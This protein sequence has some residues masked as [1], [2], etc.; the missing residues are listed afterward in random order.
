LSGTSNS[1]S[2]DALGTSTSGYGTL[3]SACWGS[4]MTANSGS[5]GNF[6]IVRLTG[7]VIPVEL[8]SFTASIIDNNVT[9]NWSTASETNNNG[10]EIERNSGN[11]FITIGFVQGYG[12]TTEVQNYTFADNGL[13]PGTYSYRLKQIDFDGT[14][15]Y[16]DAI[17][18]DVLAPTEFSLEQNYPNPFNPETVIKYTVAKE[19]FVN[20]SVYDVLGQK[21]AELVNET[22]K[23]GRHEVNFDASHLSSGVYFYKLST[24][25]FDKAAEFTR[26]K[27]MILTK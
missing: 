12:T 21:V 20:L 26:I 15:E 22:T 4:G 6:T 16:S 18:A 3:F 1:R 11:G 7:A 17:E 2:T 19:S 27:K 14:F 25:S 10:F 5:Q 23:A 8:I 13:T 9:L 24:G